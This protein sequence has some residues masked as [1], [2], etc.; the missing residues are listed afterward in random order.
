LIPLWSPRFDA[1]GGLAPGDIVCFS[2]IDSWHPDPELTDALREGDPQFTRSL[3]E[4]MFPPFNVGSPY[5]RIPVH[6]GGQQYLRHRTERG[7]RA[8]HTE[9]QD[10]VSTRTFGMSDF[11]VKAGLDFRETEL[12]EATF[13]RMEFLVAL[14][15]EALRIDQ[16]V[17]RFELLA[18]ANWPAGHVL[19]R[20]GSEWN[21]VGGDTAA[22]LAAGLAVI[23]A[24]HPW[25]RYEHLELVMTY[26]AEEAALQDPTYLASRTG[27]EYGQASLEDWTR[28]T[29]R[30]LQS[31]NVGDLLV[32]SDVN[33][34]AAVLW[35]ETA[36]LKINDD[37]KVNVSE[38][39]G[40]RIFAREHRMNGGRVA[41]MWVDQDRTT[42]WRAADRRMRQ[43]VHDYSTAVKFTNVVA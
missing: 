43:V 4:F 22:D 41:G 26:D 37:A 36:F 19:D 39:R 31:V 9:I 13:R 18:D 20:T 32:K 1:A 5:I 7:L 34:A 6:G 8:P 27:I 2:G 23:K 42:E 11:G 10:S 17:I 40:R 16:E 30:R 38:A 25:V 3:G 28:Y 12:A 24:A 35:G 21:S 15:D 33:S 29:A 14:M